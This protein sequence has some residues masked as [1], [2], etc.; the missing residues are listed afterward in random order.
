MRGRPLHLT[1]R[2]ACAFGRRGVPLLACAAVLAA[3]LCFARASAAAWPTPSDDP[4]APEIFKAP[5]PKKAPAPKPAPP[6]APPPA[7]APKPR[8]AQPAPQS[9]LP[10]TVLPPTKTAPPPAK[11]SAAEPAPPP[12]QA[13]VRFAFLG[14]DADADLDA[15]RKRDFEDY[16]TIAERSCI[17]CFCSHAYG[18]RLVESFNEVYGFSPE[19]KA[20]WDKISRC[21]TP[22]LNSIPQVR[23]IAL[24]AKFVD[25]P[26]KKILFFFS[27]FTK[28]P[29]AFRL[30]TAEPKALGPA[31]ANE[32]GEPQHI[33]DIWM[34]WKNGE[35]LM[36]YD[37]Y[38]FL[39]RRHATAKLYVYFMSN[40]RE[41]VERLI[42]R[43]AQP[44][45]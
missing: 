12:P 31:L 25:L 32:Y 30:E 18:E 38:N 3:S 26:F 29:I 33:K 16:T 24:E 4:L 7:A 13:L 10:Q 11:A 45:K 20:A 27:E 28:K 39:F 21:L 40:Y 8:D 37:M 19:F 34:I 5:E 1:T 36:I 43:A 17:G 22:A 2:I 15:A 23:S 42:E 41:H 44:P 35:D 14:M 9:A 6:P